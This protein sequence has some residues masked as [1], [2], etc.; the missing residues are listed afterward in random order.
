MA[1]HCDI[2]GEILLRALKVKVQH[3]VALRAMGAHTTVQKRKLHGPRL[4]REGLNTDTPTEVNALPIHVIHHSQAPGKWVV[5]LEV[6]ADTAQLPSIMLPQVLDGT[7]VEELLGQ[8]VVVYVAVV[9]AGLRI[10]R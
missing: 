9:V 3:L 6:A 5:L 2:G 1:G 4:L 8:Q 7:V 10:T